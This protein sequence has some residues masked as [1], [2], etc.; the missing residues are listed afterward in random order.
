MPRVGM[1]A[2]LMGLSALVQVVD[3]VIVRYLAKEGYDPQF[4]ARPLKRA[5]QEFLLDPLAMKLLE[6]EFKPGDRISAALDNGELK[7][8][9]EK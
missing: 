5:I 2:A 8:K 1:A 3:S 4:G 7:F 9:H 6:G